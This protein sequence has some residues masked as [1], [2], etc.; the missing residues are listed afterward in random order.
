[1]GGFPDGTARYCSSVGAAFDLDDDRTFWAEP[2]GDDDGS[3]HPSA[4]SPSWLR[5]SL[6]APRVLTGATVSYGASMNYTLEV[7]HASADG[8]W[9]VVAAHTCEEDTGCE[10]GF[11][12]TWRGGYDV[13]REHA[14]KVVEH[15]FHTGLARVAHARIRIT[16]S[17]FGGWACGDLCLWSNAIFALRFW[18]EAEEEAARGAADAAT[19]R[20]GAGAS[21][22]PL[23]GPPLPAQP[24]GRGGAAASCAAVS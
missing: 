8:P 19:L 5:V 24:A 7:A 4:A 2:G 15:A 21:A 14:P 16:H 18:G 20:G 22:V 9:L 10:I 11:A 1:V 3:P 12:A 13:A 17:A 6:G 23:Q